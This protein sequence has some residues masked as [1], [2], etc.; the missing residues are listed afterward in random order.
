[1][2]QKILFIMTVLLGA[3]GCMAQNI[4]LPA[5]SKT[6]GKT[7]MEAL[8][9]RESGTEFSDRML[10]RQ[11]LANLLFAAIG[12]NRRN[13][14]L[15]TP[16]AGNKQEIRVFVFTAEG[17][18]EYLNAENSL[19]PV[20]DGDRRNLIAG[21]QKW[22]MDAPVVLLIVS[23]GTKFGRVDERARSV[24]AMDAGIVSQNINIFCAAAGLVTRPRG[25]MD[26]KALKILLKLDDN[27]LPMLNN[28]VGYRK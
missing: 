14:K 8:W 15:T 22:V 9:A 2:K 1:M 28:P 6:G 12:V 19:K 20:A 27:Q 24:M 10:S 26:A 18:S 21:R 5:P 16:T 4:Q 7:M 17:V 25:S 23:D 3:I 11:D 13:G